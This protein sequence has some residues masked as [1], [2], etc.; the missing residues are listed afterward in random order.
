MSTR[1]YACLPWV[2]FLLGL[3]A[4]ASAEDEADAV[5]W[6]ELLPTGWSLDEF[7]HPIFDR[8]DLDELDDDDPIALQA[9][10]ELLELSRG[11]PLNQALHGR[12]GRVPG[13][14]EALTETED[15]DVLE[16]I[17]MPFQYGCVHRPPPPS[18]QMVHVIPKSP[19]PAEMLVRIVWASGVIE[20][21]HT[22]FPH[23]SAGYRIRDAEIRRFD[24][25]RDR[26]A[27]RGMWIGQGLR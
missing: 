25:A 12:A 4:G 5:T 21:G 15:G 16:F 2:F 9:M 23:A 17:L 10:A 18:N 24:P 14:M 20:V 8:E 26:Q 1:L 11:L 22:H 27:M 6:Q 3:Q 7:H 19:V 13:F